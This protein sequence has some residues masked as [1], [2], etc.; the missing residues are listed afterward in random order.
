MQG[1]KSKMAKTTKTTSKPAAKKATAQKATA[2][3]KKK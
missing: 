3:A 1:W 2:K